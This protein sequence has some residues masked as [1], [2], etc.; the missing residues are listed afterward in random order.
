MASAHC[1]PPCWE[2]WP[3]A[4]RSRASG[5][6]RRGEARGILSRRTLVELSC[7]R[8]APSDEEQPS[9]EKR[10]GPLP[11]LHVRSCPIRGAFPCL[12]STLSASQQLPDLAPPSPAASR[13]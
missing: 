13:Q 6:V 10:S 1:P 9:A 3:A 5:Q 12:S 4:H 11:G 8:P 2:P 7:W